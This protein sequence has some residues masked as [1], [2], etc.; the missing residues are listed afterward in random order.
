MRD[1]ERAAAQ[2]EKSLSSILSVLQ[3][4]EAAETLFKAR[5]GNDAG[6]QDVSTLS[7]DIRSHTARLQGALADA[8]GKDAG[9]ARDLA[10]PAIA[11]LLQ[12]LG[13]SK[14]ELDA[15]MPSGKP[16]DLLTGEDC[17]REMAVLED[18]LVTISGLIDERRRLWRRLRHLLEAI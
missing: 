13:K 18:L 1:V 7:G 8:R 14:A 16:V 4:E 6:G 9:I 10:S 17:N 15:M 5:L 11:T 3:D 2:A 12:L